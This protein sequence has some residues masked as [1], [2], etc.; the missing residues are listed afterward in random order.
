MCGNVLNDCESRINQFSDF[1]IRDKKK[2]HHNMNFHYLV[3][4]SSLGA[5]R[6]SPRKRPSSTRE[7]MEESDKE[8]ETDADTPSS[9]WTVCSTYHKQFH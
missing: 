8:F 7:M 5:L 3:Q 4:K 9:S 2:T 1:I 6:R